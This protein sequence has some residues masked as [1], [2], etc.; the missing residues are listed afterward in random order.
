MWRVDGRLTEV[1]IMNI[2]LKTKRF[3][4]KFVFGPGEDCFRSW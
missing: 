1:Q 3:L 4:V 2:L